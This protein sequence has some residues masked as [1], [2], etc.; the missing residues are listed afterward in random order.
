[1]EL[2]RFGIKGKPIIKL[3]LMA[4][5]N[6]SAKNNSKNSFSK[7]TNRRSTRVDLTPMV[8]LGFLL[9]T[10]FVFTTAMSTPKVMD[11]NE[12]R[13]K[14]KPTRD[15]GVMTI[16]IGKDHQLFYYYQV[17]QSQLL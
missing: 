8:D 9:I 6:T 1:M 3:I 5:I 4:E 15:S 7:S 11:L 12:P 16:L 14:P 10:F 13:D 2:I 17:Q